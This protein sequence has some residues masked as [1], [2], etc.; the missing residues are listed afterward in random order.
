[1]PKT[2]SLCPGCSACPAVEITETEVRIGE[3][4]NL[5]RLSPAEWNLLVRAIKT[6]EV[7]EIGSTVEGREGDTP[8]AKS[9]VVFNQPG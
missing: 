4:D 6:G 8:M 7:R 3:G 5:V 1:M 2:A 9:V